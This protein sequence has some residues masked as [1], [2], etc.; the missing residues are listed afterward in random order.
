M[1]VQ[2][3]KVWSETTH[4]GWKLSRQFLGRG[5]IWASWALSLHAAQADLIV[6]CRLASGFSASVNCVSVAQASTEDS[7][8]PIGLQT[9]YGHSLGGAGD[10]IMGDGLELPVTVWS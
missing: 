1:F 3:V 4:F 6:V 8:S 2:N 9:D 7:N 5:F 10:L